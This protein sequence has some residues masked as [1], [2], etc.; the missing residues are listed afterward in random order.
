MPFLAA[1][2]SRGAVSENL[3]TALDRAFGN[4]SAFDPAYAAELP[5]ASIAV[6]QRNAARSLLVL[7]K[8]EGE[9]LHWV[10]ADNSVLVTRHG[11]LIKTVGLI[12]DVQQTRFIDLDFLGE[13]SGNAPGGVRRREVDLMPGH[14]YGIMLHAEA[15]PVGAD[16]LHTLNGPVNT[17]QW[18]ERCFAPQL[19][20]RFDNWFWREEKGGSVWRSQQ[21]IAPGGQVL[22]IQLMK[23]PHG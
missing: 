3:K 10:S 23:A 16:V 8:I 6:S 11:R 1:C 20:W 13:T 17:I 22:D 4:P 14:R 19:G 18:R 7:A 21:H 2:G 15:E 12:H 5:Y 9:D